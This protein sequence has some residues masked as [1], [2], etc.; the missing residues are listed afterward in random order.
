MSNYTEITIIY[1]PNSTGPG[2]DMTED[3][4]S[5]LRSR[6]PRQ[7]IAVLATE[8]V[9]HAEELGYSLSKHSARP[10][11]ISA[12]G[13][14]GYHELINGIMKAQNEGAKPVS[15]LLPA[16]NANDHFH[17]M[18]DD[19]IVKLIEKG[20]EKR[21]DLLKLT[22]ATDSGDKVI[23][24]AHSY[25]GAGLTP[26]VGKEL[27]KTSLNWFNELWIVAKVLL[28]LRPTRLMVDGKVRAY[29]SIILSN[30]EKMSKVFTLSK[31]STPNDNLFEI[32][33]FRRRNKLKL[34]GLL[35]RASTVGLSGTT[36]IREF[37][38]STI[39]PTLIQLDGEVLEIEKEQQAVVTVEHK[40]L[41]CIV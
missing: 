10:L 26:K 28:F 6:L 7:K 25:I 36:K 38:F 34:I 21:I 31:N 29:D 37:I 12:S 3:L 13:D 1:N 11:I 15:G 35:L 22:T 20:Q 32:T 14:G 41:R 40:A 8:Y 23:R 39:K 17:S 19:D 27:N 30:I 18:H 4:V 16:G 9:K 2:K 33:V 5:K 24:Y